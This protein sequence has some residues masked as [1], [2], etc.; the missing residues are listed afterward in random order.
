MPE[1]DARSR[2]SPTDLERR[3]A[4][5]ESHTLDRW[6]EAVTAGATGS[7]TVKAMEQT[8]SWRITRPLRLTLTV[9]KRVRAAGPRKTFALIR[10]RLAAQ[11]IAKQR[12]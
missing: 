2:P 9:A 12:D 3:L 1:T 11:R 5:A 10:E 8:L 7:M 4:A 6:I